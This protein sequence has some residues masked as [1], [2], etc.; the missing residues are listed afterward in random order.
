[1]SSKQHASSTQIGWSE[2][3]LQRNCYAECMNEGFASTVPCS[4]GGLPSKLG[5]ATDAPLTQDADSSYLD[6]SGGTGSASVF[7]SINVLEALA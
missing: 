5:R 2:R 4:R 6:M 1:M 7:L 3:V